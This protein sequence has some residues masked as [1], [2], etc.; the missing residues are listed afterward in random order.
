[1]PIK[2]L[3]HKLIRENKKKKIKIK[4]KNKSYKLELLWNESH[5]YTS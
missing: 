3:L 5:G 1:M 2:K 4:R